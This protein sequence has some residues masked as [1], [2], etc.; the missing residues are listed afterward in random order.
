LQKA[1]A[2][3]IDRKRFIFSEK[4]VFIQVDTRKLKKSSKVFRP[5]LSKKHL[6]LPACAFFCA[7]DINRHANRLPASGSDRLRSHWHLKRER[8]CGFF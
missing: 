3:T 8:T 7:D 5:F 6:L 1:Q 4:A 2:Q